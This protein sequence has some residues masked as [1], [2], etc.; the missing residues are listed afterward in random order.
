MISIGRAILVCGLFALAGLPYCHAA[1]SVTPRMISQMDEVEE[2]VVLKGVADLKKCPEDAFALQLMDDGDL[3]KSALPQLKKF[4]SLRKLRLSWCNVPAELW[5]HVNDCSGLEYLEVR[6]S[7]ISDADFNELRLDKLV[8]LDISSCSKL[9]PGMFSKLTMCPKLEV[10]KAERFRFGPEERLPSLSFLTALSVLSLADSLDLTDRQLDQLITGAPIRELS[11]FNNSKLVDLAPGL[12]ELHNLTKLNLACCS[13][14]SDAAVRGVST[15]AKLEHLNLC[16]PNSL[17]EAGFSTL[18]SCS[19]IQ[20]LILCGGEKVTDAAMLK[21]SNLTKLVYLD[22]S[23]CKLITGSGFAALSERKTLETL[24]A[25]E[26][27]ALEDSGLTH[28]EKIKSLTQIDVDLCPKITDSALRRLEAALP[29]CQLI[30]PPGLGS[31]KG[32]K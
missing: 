11:L 27:E 18:G 20:E 8:L 16:A 14:L 31:P 32:T 25:S 7:N 2:Y 19:Q 3:L 13:K 22:I 23:R 10:L 15:C 26:C 4:K 5:K 29:D 24:I 17:T 12:A 1:Q 28:L 30:P 9:T 21:W 6:A